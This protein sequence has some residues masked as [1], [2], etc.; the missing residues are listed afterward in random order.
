[1]IKALAFIHKKLN[2]SQDEFKNYYEK[3]HA[4]LANSLLA[5]EGYERNYV[6]GCLSPLFQS[7]GSISIFKYKSAKSLEVIGEQMTSNAGDTL[8]KDELNFMNVDKN[9]YLLTESNELSN[10]TFK[11]KIFYL[12]NTP[13][14]LI[15]LDGINGIIKISD[16]LILD[17]E[18][19]VGVPEYGITKSCVAK[20]L[21]QLQEEYPKTIIATSES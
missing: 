1:M 3:N 13:A 5:L 12:A 10:E 16:N 6:H 2:L 18:N 7:L 19:I 8:R 17:H 20:N 14:E 11:K 21:D 9:F 15:H 4:P